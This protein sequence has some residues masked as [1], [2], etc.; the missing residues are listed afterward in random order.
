[1]V[2]IG[3]VVQF[4]V[5]TVREKARSCGPKFG[6]SSLGLCFSILYEK[7]S[8]IRGGFSEFRSGFDL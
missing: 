4:L 8:L 5:L 1:M 6:D 7:L 3:A 2:L